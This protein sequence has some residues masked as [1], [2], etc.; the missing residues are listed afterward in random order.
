MKK[1]KTCKLL[2]CKKKFTPTQFAQVVC[3]WKCSIEY[4]K[5]KKAKKEKKQLTID[6]REFKLNDKKT[7]KNLAWKA[8][9]R[10]IRLRDKDLGCI[11]CGTKND[12]VYAAG[13]FRSRGAMGA[14]MF[15]EDNV[16]KQCNKYCNKELSSN[17]VNYK[18]ALIEKIGLERVE[19]LEGHHEPKQYTVQY[20]VEI[21]LKYLK[22]CREME[23]S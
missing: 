7:Q 22:L 9:S 4:D 15:H 10:F 11:S 20:L 2:T 3:D 12:V 21:K 6:R 16:H 18:P 14:L 17:Y 13:H 5:Q 23:A 19:W 8:F 1:Q